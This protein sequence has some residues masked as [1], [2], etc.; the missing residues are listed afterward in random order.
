MARMK[1]FE[2]EK[3]CDSDGVPVNMMFLVMM[4]M[5]WIF[6]LLGSWLYIRVHRLAP[7]ASHPHSPFSIIPLHV[8]CSVSQISRLLSWFALRKAGIL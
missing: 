6:L 3:G 8:A 2:L 5:K 7:L 4:L 1:L